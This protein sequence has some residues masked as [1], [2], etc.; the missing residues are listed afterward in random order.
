M[1]NYSIVLNLRGSAVNNSKK[2]ADNLERADKAAKSLKGNLQNMPKVPTGGGGGYRSQYGSSVGGYVNVATSFSTQSGLGS[3]YKFAGKANVYLAMID[4]A[5]RG[6]AKAVTTFAK[7][8]VVAYTGGAQL[9]KKGADFLVSSQ[10]GE[11][12]RLAQRRQQARLGFG[13]DYE[14][15]QRRADLLAASY[16]LNP[17]DVVASMNVLTGMKVNGRKISTAQAERLTQVG[18]LIAQHSGMSFD[19][20]MINIQQMM[21]QAVPSMRDIRQ[22]LTHAPILGRYALQEMKKRGIKGMTAMEYL[23]ADKAGLMA[24]FERYLSENPSLLAMRARGIVQQANTGFYAELTHVPEWLRLADRYSETMG[25]LAEAMKS[26]ISAAVDSPALSTSLDALIEFL[27]SAPTLIT[28]LTSN[29]D[30]LLVSF[31]D[32]LPTSE[33]GFIEAAQV[34]TAKRFALK[35]WVEKNYEA[36]APHYETLGLQKNASRAEI[37]EAAYSKILS[38]GALDDFLTPKTFTNVYVDD[39]RLPMWQYTSEGKVEHWNAAAKG[40]MNHSFRVEGGAMIQRETYAK[41][42]KDFIPFGEEVQSIAGVT[43]NTEAIWTAIS[44]VPKGVE[45]LGSLAGDSQQGEA[46]SGYGAD[47]KSLVINFNAPIVEWDSTIN[48]D[49]PDD[50]VSAVSETI[51]GAAT[52]AIQIAL[53]GATG[54]MSSRF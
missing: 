21:S 36:I 6:A 31:G 50:V 43:P 23:K 18:G 49:D 48:T 1:A 51:E 32:F 34:R 5:L 47:R 27:R 14:E 41:R 24:V 26:L 29:L 42:H 40:V 22:L 17:S 4:A 53:L 9:L 7:I 15:A 30:S 33:S 46:I 54:T 25:V 10:F 39:Y 35:S 3:V 44:F 19:T 20:V 28:A 12:I 45:R 37:I 8:N 38:K 16:G 13:E 11:G 52:R 2:L